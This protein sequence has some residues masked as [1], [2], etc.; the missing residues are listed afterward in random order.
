MR[1]AAGIRVIHPEDIYQSRWE[2]SNITHNK[3]TK[4]NTVSM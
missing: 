2:N 1:P 3:E 4:Y